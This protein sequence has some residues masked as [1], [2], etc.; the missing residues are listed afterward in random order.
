MCNWRAT[1]VYDKIH[2]NA[3]HPTSTESQNSN[4]WVQVLI[5]PSF[6]FECVPIDIK[7]SEFSDS[8][9]FEDGIFSGIC[10]TI[11]LMCV[12]CLAKC[13]VQ[14]DVLFKVTYLQT[15]SQT[16]VH[17]YV[18]V[19]LCVCMCACVCMCVRI[20]VCAC[21]RACTCV[22]VSACVCMCT[23][24]CVYTYINTSMTCIYT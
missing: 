15:L 13:L 18:Y 10:H 7:R 19:Y 24:S 20:C 4:F 22:Y 1:T 9:D 17:V 3:T 6:R 11:G 21:A 16:W 14:S 8:V 12:I 23:C 2:W 5:G